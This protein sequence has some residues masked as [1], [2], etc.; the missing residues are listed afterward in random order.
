MAWSPPATDR[1]QSQGWVLSLLEIWSWNLCCASA[2]TLGLDFVSAYLILQRIGD[3]KRA[4]WMDHSVLKGSI[5][6]LILSIVASALPVWLKSHI[7]P[8]L[9][10]KHLFSHICNLDLSYIININR[11]QWWKVLVTYELNQ[12]D[13]PT[14][15]RLIIFN[16]G[17]SLDRE[18]A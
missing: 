10:N 9:R 16:Q 17:L 11:R 5:Q 18:R 12:A 14:S 15:K 2:Y 1:S 7:D 6:R 13:H 8:F 4:L 3:L